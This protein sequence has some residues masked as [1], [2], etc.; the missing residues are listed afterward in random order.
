MIRSDH[1]LIKVAGEVNEKIQQINDYLGDRNCE[2]GKIRFPRGYLR[3]CIHH[4]NKY[5]FVK[6]IVLRK[7]IA[8]A[9]LTTDVF[10]WILNRTDI[11]IVAKEM[12]IKQ[13]ISILGSIAESIT[14]EYLKGKPGGGKNYKKRLQVLLGDGIL[15]E[16]LKEE[17]EWLWDVR[18]NLHLMM[19]SDPEYNKYK[20]SDYNRA[21]C[22]LSDLRA[23]LGGIA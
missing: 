15:G 6:D 10:R 13:G 7:N 20:M 3:S 4:R 12:L 23:A 9:L 5:T 16:E 11:S 18:N 21:I 22:A 17:L 1:D 14:K 2:E 19:L 8:Y